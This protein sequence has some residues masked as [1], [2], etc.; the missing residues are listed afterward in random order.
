M[1]ISIPNKILVSSF[2][3]NK[4]FSINYKLN[5]SYIKVIKKRQRHYKYIESS[6]LREK[7]YF[8]LAG[9]AEENQLKDHA[10]LL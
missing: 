8:G 4:K 7:V 5:Y 6:I 1:I 9:R 3:K 2:L 10:N